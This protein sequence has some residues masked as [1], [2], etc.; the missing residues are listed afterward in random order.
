MKLFYVFRYKTRNTWVN[1]NYAYGMTSGLAVTVYFSALLI[2]AQ[3]IQG[4]RVQENLK[5][6]WH[7]QSLIFDR[8]QWSLVWC[9]NAN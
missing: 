7:F 3:Q 2:F 5:K 6:V 4:L 9:I 8:T 1:T